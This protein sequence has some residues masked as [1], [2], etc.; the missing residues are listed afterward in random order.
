MPAFEG[1]FP[2]QYDNIVQDLLFDLAA[3]HAF[4]KMRLHTDSTLALF[5]II[6]ASLG[7]TLRLFASEVCTHVKTFA[8]PR[9]VEATQ[10]RAAKAAAKSKSA[11][12]PVTEN[13]VSFLV[14]LGLADARA[15]TALTGRWS[16]CGYTSCTCAIVDSVQRS[17]THQG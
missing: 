12:P 2:P 7:R 17:S 13:V 15:L 6:T 14:V 1:L 3:W 10:R 16:I 8:L 11:G 9:E 4:A 5:E